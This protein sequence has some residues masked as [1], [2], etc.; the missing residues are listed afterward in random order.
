MFLLEL[1]NHRIQCV[2][3]FISLSEGRGSSS[4]SHFVFSPLDL[5]FFASMPSAILPTEYS[6]HIGLQYFVRNWQSTMTAQNGFFVGS[7]L[8]GIYLDSAPTSSWTEVQF[9]AYQQDC[10]TA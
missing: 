2:I 4:I 7:V 8:K 9:K 6:T 10:N 5:L 1:R 3:F